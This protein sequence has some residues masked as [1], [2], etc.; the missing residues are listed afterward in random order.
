VALLLLAPALSG[1][2][3]YL[4]R[5]DSITYAA[6]NAPETN[7]AIHTVN[8][9]PPK[10]WDTTIIADGHPVAKAQRAY[11]TGKVAPPATYGTTSSSSTSSPT[12]TGAN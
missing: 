12:S 9:F 10:A 1:C 8:P 4:A 2:A 6:G 3:D 5:R 7:T 11:D